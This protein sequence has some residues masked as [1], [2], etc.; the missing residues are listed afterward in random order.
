MS[1]TDKIQLRFSHTEK[2][3]VAAIRHHL[4]HST[5]V[6]ARV[7]VIYVLISGG[8]LL[9]NVVLDFLLP[10]WSVV[11]LIFLLGVAWAHAYLVDF[12]RRYFR[13]EPKFR[14]EYNLIF[15]DA[16][17]QFNTPDVNASIAWSLYT[18]VAENK[19][20]YVLIY[21]RNFPSLSIVPKRAFR[22]NKQETAFREM[23]RRNVTGSLKLSDGERETNEYVPVS[24]QPPDW[25]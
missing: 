11:A 5:E 18:G 13:S 24:S 3:Y 16:S 15:T 25:R 14:Q 2:E 21:G 10:L 6:M 19:S 17:I 23:V 7:I 12:P 1:Y 8:L 22:D 4:L 20:S 9:L